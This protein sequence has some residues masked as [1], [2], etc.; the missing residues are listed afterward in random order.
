MTN[1]IFI[2]SIINDDRELTNFFKNF[3]KKYN[4]VSR[5]SDNY[6]H[7]TFQSGETE[8]LQKIKSGLRII[9]SNTKLIKIEIIGL[10][11]WSEEWVYYRI[12]KTKELVRLNQ[13]IN[14]LLETYC[15][16]LAVDYKPK[17]W[18]PHIAIGNKIQKSEFQKAFEEVSSKHIKKTHRITSIYIVEQTPSGQFRTL[19]KYELSK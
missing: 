10:A 1:R 13:V 9:S 19:D 17:L 7:I 8:E 4:G 12:R 2:L 11:N 14:D 5:A 3:E 15:K 16:K 18:V 6:L